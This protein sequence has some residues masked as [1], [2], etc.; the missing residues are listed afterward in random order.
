MSSFK[1]SAKAKGDLKDIA[2]HTQDQWGSAQRKLYL[3]QLDDA[4]HFLATSPEIGTPFDWI[5]AGYKKFPQGSHVIFYRV[6]A[7]GNIEI[8]RV[9]HKRM[10]ITT[11]L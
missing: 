5:K 2:K 7:Q 6:D 4:F 9:L 1:L 8:I 11:H 3:K 10:D